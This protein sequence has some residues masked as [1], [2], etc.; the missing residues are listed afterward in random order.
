MTSTEVH[1]GTMGRVSGPSAALSG[2]EIKAS[3]FAGGYLPSADVMVLFQ[4]PHAYVSPSWYLAPGVPTWNYVV[5]HVYGTAQILADDTKTE[6][7]IQ[8]PSSRSSLRS[9][10]PRWS[11]AFSRIWGCRLNRHHERRRG[12]S[13][14]FRRLETQTRTGSSQSRRGGSC[15]ARGSVPIGGFW[16]MRGPDFS[17]K[18]RGL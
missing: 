18:Y 14:F 11:S 3:G 17:R 13:I 16:P 1:S 8:R 4:G 5:A 10:S 6:N 12:A 9:K 15:R 7:I 2:S